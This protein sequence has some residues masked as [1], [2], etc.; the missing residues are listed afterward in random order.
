MTGKPSCQRFSA[1]FRMRVTYKKLYTAA[2]YFSSPVKVIIF[3][4]ECVPVLN[5]PLKEKTWTVYDLI[6]TFS[7]NDH[8]KDPTFGSIWQYLA[9]NKLADPHM[10]KCSCSLQILQCMNMIGWYSFVLLYIFLTFRGN[11]DEEGLT[12][13]NQI[14]FA[15]Y[16]WDVW[17]KINV[18]TFCICLESYSLMA[19]MLPAVD[20]FLCLAG[21]KLMP[22]C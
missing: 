5:A 16:K 19:S 17:E 13:L 1:F 6:I 22:A 10:E 3:W 2:S 8:Y 20:P 12:K 18:C 14:E 4:G 21:S 9:Y 15:I 7:C 11:E